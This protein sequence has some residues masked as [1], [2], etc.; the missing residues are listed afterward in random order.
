[1]PINEDFFPRSRRAIKI[2]TGIFSIFRG[3]MRLGKKPSQVE[4]P[5]KSNMARDHG[6]RRIV[7]TGILFG[8]SRITIQA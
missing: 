4:A 1:M 6:K 7:T 3:T 8:I 2:T 5:A